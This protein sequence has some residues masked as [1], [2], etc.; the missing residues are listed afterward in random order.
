MGAITGAPQIDSAPAR[1]VLLK[2]RTIDVGFAGQ[3]FVLTCCSIGFAINRGSYDPTRTQ[4]MKSVVVALAL[5]ANA[6]AFDIDWSDKGSYSQ[7]REKQMLKDLNEISDLDRGKEYF[8]ISKEKLYKALTN[9]VKRGFKS[10][11]E[12]DTDKSREVN[13]DD[14]ILEIMSHVLYKDKKKPNT[15][16]S[17]VLRCT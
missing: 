15:I 1:S 2:T 17:V 9:A 11:K 14:E 3:F 6:Q 7:R 8:R 4:T 12:Y 16:R 10:K 13:E 5:A